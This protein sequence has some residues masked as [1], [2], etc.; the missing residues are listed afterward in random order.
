MDPATAV[1]VVEREA[2]AVVGLLR[3]GSLDAPVAGCPGWSV[4]D[5]GRHLGGVHRWARRAVTAGRSE[6]PAGSREPSAV[7]GWVEEGAAN[8]VRTLRDVD[9][10]TPCW[11]LAEP[12]AARFWMRRQAHETTLHR[13]DA[14]TSLGQPTGIEDAVALDG[15]DEVA[16]MFLP[17]QVRLGRMAPRPETVELVAAS[18]SST[19]LAGDPDRPRDPTAMVTGPAEAL[20]L[21]VWKRIPLTD[22]RLSVSGSLRDAE[23]L[24]SAPLTP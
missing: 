14:A 4:A 20:L 12:R 17:R 13:W 10:D 7:A 16:T 1:D 3:D 6:P 21:L 22:G 24:L 2:R 5:L 23:R 15:L 9:P 11:A 19:R 18:G 8:L